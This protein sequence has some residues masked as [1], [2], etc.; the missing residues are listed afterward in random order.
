MFHSIQPLGDNSRVNVWLV[1]ETLFGVFSSASGP[2]SATTVNG[3]TLD[4]LI[5]GGIQPVE[6]LAPGAPIPSTGNYFGRM[7]LLQTNDGVGLDTN[8]N[9]FLATK[10]YKWT[11]GGTPASPV[12]GKGSWSAAVEAVDITGNLTDSQ[13]ASLSAAKLTGQ[14]TSTQITDGAISTPKLAAGAV[15]TANLAADA[16]VASKI[17]AGAITAGKIAA[18]V[19]TATELA[20]DS[21][22]AGK[23]AAGA[24]V[25]SAVGTNEIIAHTANIKDGIITSAKIGDAEITTAKIATANITTL[26]ID[27]NAVTVPVSA[28]STGNQGIIMNQT[29]D[30]QTVNIDVLG[31]EPVALFVSCQMTAPDNFDF[32]L[33]LVRDSTIIYELFVDADIATKLMT[34]IFAD[35]PGAG[36]YNYKFQVYQHITGGGTTNVTNFSQR[37]LMAISTKR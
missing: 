25:A 31:S 6:I 37:F 17:A 16:V 1:V 3:I 19:V 28:L 33:R 10:V 14:I 18:G 27:G 22:V 12:S 34:F 20:A 9:P 30:M 13:I 5:I 7:V 21:V 24:I 26:L 35:S 15:E 11:G 23:I 2:H 29:I 4:H 36:N 32:S 8:G